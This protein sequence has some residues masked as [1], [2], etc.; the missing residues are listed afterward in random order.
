M[1]K[2]WLATDWEA[3][4]KLF[5]QMGGKQNQVLFRDV[6]KAKGE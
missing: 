1:L 4:A 5:D 3:E 2:D 6:R